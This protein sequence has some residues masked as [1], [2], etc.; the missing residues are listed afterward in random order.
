M[1]LYRNN[2]RSIS[3]HAHTDTL[4]LSPICH[5]KQCNRV[6]QKLVGHVNQTWVI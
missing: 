6:L 3:H 5:E 4:D 1:D 2:I